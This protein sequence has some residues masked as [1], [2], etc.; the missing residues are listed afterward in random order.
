[1]A[2]SRMRKIQI[3]AHKDAQ[4]EIVSAL[5][6]GGVLHITEPSM[7]LPGGGD[8]DARREAERELLSRLN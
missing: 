6:E 5:R 3:L 8:D 1:M 7:E 4:D 2:V